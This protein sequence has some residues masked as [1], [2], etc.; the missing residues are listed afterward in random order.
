MGNV[1]HRNSGGLAQLADGVG[2]LRIRIL[3]QEDQPGVS[4]LDC[5]ARLLHS[6][7]LMFRLQLVDQ[8]KSPLLP[9]ISAEY[10]Y[11]TQISII[12][13]VHLLVKQFFP[14]NY[15]VFSFYLFI[16]YINFSQLTLI[17]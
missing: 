7:H 16:S 5:L 17:I 4:P 15:K 10:A 2:D 13:W 12:A 14:C 8:S 3:R 9:D 11:T 6:N 1:L